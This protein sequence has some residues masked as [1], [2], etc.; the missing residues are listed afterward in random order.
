MRSQRVELQFVVR[1]DA[2]DR[3]CLRGGERQIFCDVLHDPGP[4][5]IAARRINGICDDAERSTTASTVEILALAQ[6]AAIERDA[7]EDSDREH[8]D[9]G[10]HRHHARTRCSHRI[11]RS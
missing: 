11:S 5:A 8:R 6:H 4:H 3:C 7:G 2:V 1:E 10:Q 9:D